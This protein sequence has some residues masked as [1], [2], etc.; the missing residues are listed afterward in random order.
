[1]FFVKHAA[2]GYKSTLEINTIENRL[3]YFYMI[4]CAQCGNTNNENSKF[5]TKCGTLLVALFIHGK[6]EYLNTVSA[7]GISTNKIPGSGWLNNKKKLPLIITGCILGLL[8]TVIFIT[9]YRK[10]NI[11]SSAS[12]T[13]LQE[14]S[15]NTNSAIP[16]TSG[17]MLVKPGTQNTGII[18]KSNDILKITPAYKVFYIGLDNPITI[19]SNIDPDKIKLS[20]S[21]GEIDGFGSSRNVRVNN[22]GMAKISAVIKGKTSIFSFPVKRIPDPVVKIGSGRPR[23]P[24]VEFKNQQFCRAELENFDIPD[25]HFSVVN[26]DV[27]FSGE[28][29]TDSQTETIYSGSLS[30]LSQLMSMCRPG[31][32]ILFKNIKVKGPDGIRSISG[33]EIQLY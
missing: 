20:I 4:L 30:S 8:S 18:E 3:D 12:R 17:R 15:V 31:S 13:D 5:C 16:D 28:N 2:T 22:I 1:M 19:F 21:H 32:T 23:V 11:E 14:T 24:A 10:S 26:A 9:Y 33:C 7:E 6:G 29:F 25:I 27:E